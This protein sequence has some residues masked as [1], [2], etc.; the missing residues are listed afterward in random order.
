MTY[1]VLSLLTKVLFMM[2]PIGFIACG[3]GLATGDFAAYLSGL[4][5]V[6]IGWSGFCVLSTSSE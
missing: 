6:V 1:R 5:S 3:Y 2:V 4:L